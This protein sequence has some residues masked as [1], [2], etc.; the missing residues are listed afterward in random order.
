VIRIADP[1]NLG[2]ALRDI[3]NVLGYNRRE[4]ARTIAAATGRVESGVYRQLAEWD[5]SVHSPTARALGPILDALGFDLAL[6]S[7]HPEPAPTRR[8]TGTGWPDAGAL[9]PDRRTAI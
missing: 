3:R 5:Y 9:A 7:K 4:L 8:D 6:V 2:T 1:S